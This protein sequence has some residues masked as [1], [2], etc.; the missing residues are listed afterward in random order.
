MPRL[1]NHIIDALIQRWAEDVDKNLE[2]NFGI[3]SDVYPHTTT[4]PPLRS[5][6]LTMAGYEMTEKSSKR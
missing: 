5:L 6:L 2:I 1:C 4:Q 3:I